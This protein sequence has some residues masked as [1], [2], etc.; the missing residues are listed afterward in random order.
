MVKFTDAA[1]IRKFYYTG[2]DTKE[3]V[4]IYR[5]YMESKQLIHHDRIKVYY[6]T[7]ISLQNITVMSYL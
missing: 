1:F 5:T 3:L 2:Q 6:C 4:N 7:V